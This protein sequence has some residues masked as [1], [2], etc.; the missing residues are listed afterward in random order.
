MAIIISLYRK[1]VPITMAMAF[2]I[3]EEEF[4]VGVFDED[5]MVWGKVLT[6]GY[7]NGGAFNIFDAGDG[8]IVS[9]RNYPSDYMTIGRRYVAKFDKANGDMIWETSFANPSGQNDNYITEMAGY[10]DGSFICLSCIYDSV[11]NTYNFNG[12]NVGVTKFRAD[13]SIKW[14]KIY[15]A[16]DF[17]YGH[18]LTT[19]ADGG[20][21]FGGKTE[22]TG[23]SGANYLPFLMKCDANGERVWEKTYGTSGEFFDVQATVDGGYIAIGGTYIPSNEIIIVKI[24]STG[25]ESWSKLI[26]TTSS[27]N[28]CTINVVSDGYILIGGDS[29][30]FVFKIDLSGNLIWS[31]YIT[32]IDGDNTE[33][34]GGSGYYSDAFTSVK[35]VDDNLIFAGLTWYT[36]PRDPVRYPIVYGKVKASEPEIFT[37]GPSVNIVNAS[38]P[39]T[40][41]NLGYYDHTAQELELTPTTIIDLST[42]WVESNFDIGTEYMNRIAIN[43]YSIDFD[44]IY[45]YPSDII[46]VENESAGTVVNHTIWG[47]G[48]QDYG[49][50]GIG[51]TSTVTAFTAGILKD[52]FQIACGD[53]FTFVLKKDG[54]LWGCGNN[55]YGQLGLGHTSPSYYDTFQQEATGS[56]NWAF[57][58]CGGNHT[59][60]TKF[61]V[62]DGWDTRSRAYSCGLN[63]KGQCG[64]DST[65]AYF[66][67]FTEILAV[68]G[69]GWLPEVGC[70]KETTVLGGYD[71][72]SD[73]STY[74]CGANDYGQLGLDYTSLIEITP[75]ISAVYNPKGIQR[76]MSLGDNYSILCSS[77]DIHGTG[78][79]ASTGLGMGTEPDQLKWTPLYYDRGGHPDYNIAEMWKTATFS[80]AE[81]TMMIRSDGTLW[82]TG[83]NT[84]GQLGTGDTLPQD[85]F[86]QIGTDVDWKDI[87]VGKYIT[88][89]QKHDNTLWGAGAKDYGG[90][91]MSGTGNLLVHTKLS[92]D[93]FHVYDCSHY[94]I[95]ASKVI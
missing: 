16:N 82:G 42:A 85:S 56:T 52:A 69:E 28:D 63:N 73:G 38:F 47:T 75:I 86:V 53:G 5:G 21:I 22:P 24:T 26:E 94:G 37:P 48:K 55:Q 95:V 18:A 78:V 40:S 44:D 54:T 90:L 50:L 74:V 66:I 43:S 35:V 11:C 46:K 58:A 89:A 23:A 67:N 64:L 3:N 57:V 9:G 33:F 27:G 83:A 30:A 91:G 36:A 93:E 17:T 29:E 10:S 32:D 8:L 60:A 88:V 76:S 72:N 59:V 13:G 77:G 80:G 71:Y 45:I 65:G 81:V 1:P 4:G 31:K 15:E 2:H 79:N 20:F 51:S 14:G 7:D 34:G 68:D 87:K 92:D 12:Y 19:T 49:E 25:V 6:K 41:W 70:G 62:F 61:D 39:D 84:Y